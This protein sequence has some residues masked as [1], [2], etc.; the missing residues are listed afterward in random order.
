MAKSSIFPMFMKGGAA[1]VIQGELVLLMEQEP[2][3]LLEDEN[4]SVMLETEVDLVLSD[5]DIEVTIDG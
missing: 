1:Q 4:I 2:D 3:I 5:E